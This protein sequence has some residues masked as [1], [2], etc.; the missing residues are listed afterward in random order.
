MTNTDEKIAK[1]NA[2]FWRYQAQLDAAETEKE[3]DRLAGLMSNT[4]A[5]L[6]KLMELKMTE[7]SAAG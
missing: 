7:T 6:N 1:C 4:L 5:F 2:L 3:K